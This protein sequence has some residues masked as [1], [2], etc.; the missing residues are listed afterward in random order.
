MLPFLKKTEGAVSQPIKTI[1]REH[2]EGFDLLDAIA[3]DLLEAFKKGDK[4]RVKAALEA[5]VD[6]IQ[7]LDE[8]ED[9]KLLGEDHD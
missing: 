2:D 7:T 1:E 3:E 6:H 5:F 4:G 8:E 9:K